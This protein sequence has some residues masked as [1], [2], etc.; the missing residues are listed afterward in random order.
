MFENYEFNGFT[1]DKSSEHQQTNDN[2]TSFLDFCEGN[3]KKKSKVNKLIKKANQPIK[4]KLKKQGKKIKRIESNFDLLSNKLDL[5]QEE[6]MKMKKSSYTDMLYKLAESDSV[7][8]RKKILSEI[9]SAGDA[10]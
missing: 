8:M 7:I 5:V 1:T 4:E 3:K 9:L 2:E 6:L 10:K